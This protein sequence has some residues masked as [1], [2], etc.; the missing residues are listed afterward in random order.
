MYHEDWITVMSNKGS[1]Y[2]LDFARRL[3]ATMDLQ[4]ES[5]VTDADV[6]AAAVLLAQFQPAEET[7]K[8]IDMVNAAWKQL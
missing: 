5:V 6:L 1:H 8:F 2:N 3:M 7:H 4:P